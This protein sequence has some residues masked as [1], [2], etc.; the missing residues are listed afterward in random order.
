MLTWLAVSVDPGVEAD[1]N[2]L[3]EY[4]EIAV[5]V[6]IFTAAVIFTWRILNDK[7]RFALIV[8]ALALFF[9]IFVFGVGR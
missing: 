5:G 8:I 6:L 7:A 3:R 1:P 4:G 2:Q 9:G